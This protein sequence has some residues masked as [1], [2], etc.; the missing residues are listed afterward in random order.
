MQFSKSIKRNLLLQL[1]LAIALLLIA[2][3][4]VLFKNIQSHINQFGD[5]NLNAFE[6]QLNSNGELLSSLLSNVSVEAVMGLD[7]YTLQNY[8]SVLSANPDIE[9]VVFYDMSGNP[10]TPEPAEKAS[11][12]LEFSKVIKTDPQK[13][14]I[15]QEVGKVQIGLKKDKLLQREDDVQTSLSTITKNTILI[16]LFV[17]L[18]LEAAILLFLFMSLR[19]KIFNPLSEISLQLEDIA[20]GEA[21]LTKRVIEMDT[22]EIG[23]LTY[24]FNQFVNRLMNLIHKIKFIFE[25]TRE[26]TIQIIQ[27][28]QRQ[29]EILTNQ[30][31]SVQNSTEITNH[32]TNEI[33]AIHQDTTNQ[34]AAVTEIAETINDMHSNLQH[35]VVQTESMQQAIMQ[36]TSRIN[37]TLEGIEQVIERTTAAARKSN[38]GVALIEET[39]TSVAMSSAGMHNINSAMLDIRNRMQDLNRDSQHMGEIIAVIDEV[40][41]QTNLLALNA[42]IEAARAGEAGKG[43]AVVADEIRK[44][45]E[46]TS[47]ATGEI[48]Q[49]IEQALKNIEK[50]DS[51]VKKGVEEAENGIELTNKLDESITNVVNE[52]HQMNRIMEEVASIAQSQTEHISIIQ[53]T[54]HEIESSSSEISSIIKQ[55]AVGSNDIKQAIDGIDQITQNIAM[56]LTKQAENINI[57]NQTIQDLAQQNAETQDA[58]TSIFEMVQT[59]NS[60][61]SELNEFIEEFK[62]QQAEETQIVKSS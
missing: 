48:S 1:A 38:Q 46:R 32:F 59:L 42:A 24:Y 5:R 47:K 15:E 31:Q 4:Y 61:I 18:F 26:S 58:S 19:K 22:V 34:A 60:N 29:K 16:T 43:F 55:Q 33:N 62:T 25:E 20:E 8:V 44:L 28:A 37:E 17:I 50:T 2:G 11:D 21:D 52:M 36:S 53:E 6:E 23:S 57:L 45:A 40:A 10:L 41:E 39:K 14:G 12:L 49:M 35:T 13:L 9:Y 54:L 30:N 56:A 51:S 27:L 7:L 3:N